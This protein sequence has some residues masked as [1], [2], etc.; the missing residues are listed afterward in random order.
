ML[1]QSDYR[2]VVDNLFRARV[3]GEHVYVTDGSTTAIVALNDLYRWR[4][5]QANGSDSI[6]GKEYKRIKQGG[7]QGAVVWFAPKAVIA[8]LDPEATRA[9]LSPSFVVAVNEFN[10]G[11]LVG[12]RPMGSSGYVVRVQANGNWTVELAK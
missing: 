2:T 1:S 11:P 8:A 5:Q 10:K 12:D 7:F 6:G 4:V 9:D 3:A